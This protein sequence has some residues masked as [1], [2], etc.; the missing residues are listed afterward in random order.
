[1]DDGLKRV[2]RRLRDLI[3]PEGS[4]IQVSAF[5][6]LAVCGIVV[7]LITAFYNLSVGFGI[8]S[9]IE[10]MSGVFISLG[11]MVYTRRTGNYRMAM[12]LTVLAIFFGL[13][14]F[15]YLTNGGYYGGVPYFF[16]FATVFTAFL[17]DGIIMPVFVALELLWYAGLCIYTYYHPSVNLLEGNEEIRMM[18]VVVCETIVSIA[19]SIAMYLQI[20][21]YRKKQQ[22]LNEAI[23]AVREA[24]SAKSEF[25][26]KMS[27]DIRTPLNTIMAMNE[28]IVSNTSSARIREWV[29]DSNVSG[30]IL[31]S[32][33]DDMLD[34][35]RIEA[36]R[37]DLLEQPWDTEELFDEA[38]KAWKLQ[39]DRKG[40]DFYYDRDEHLPARLAGDEDV[41]RKITN[42]LLSNAVKYTRTGSVHLSVGWTDRLMIIV[43]D[44][45][46]GIAPEH[47]NN[48]FKPF[49]RG[50]QDIYRETS[51]SGLG[52]AIVKELVD[53][54][55]GSVVCESRLNHGTKFTVCLPEKT[56]DDREDAKTSGASA[57]SGDSKAVQQFVAPEAQI[58]VVDDNAYNRKVIEAFLEPTLIRI[59]DV[60]SG[61]EALEMIDIKHYDLVLMDLRMPGMD[62]AE[63]LEQIKRDYPDFDTP[64]VVLTADIMNGV[65][66][67]LLKQGFSGFLAKP[68][69]SPNLLSTIA[70]FIPDKVV[71]LQ[72]DEE[73]GLT[74]AR[75]ESFQDMLKP[76]G[77]DL[78]LAL[79]YNAG[80]TEE[81]LMRAGLF[82]DYAEENRQRLKWDE[83]QAEEYYLLV[84][85]IKSIARGVGAY[86]LAQLAE[87]IE[88]RKEDAFVEKTN[89]VLLDEYERVR[90]G[91]KKL[92][93]G[94]NAI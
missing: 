80:S 40:L 25:L 2:L 46:I 19:L 15:L 43:E 93:E 52:L 50:V 66:E 86:L 36:G 88:Y 20:R 55:G 91:L 21:V 22:Q 87:A 72:T 56:V 5:N 7:S 14:T 32:L 8:L 69:S 13:F 34:L 63:T 16:V 78:K 29:N 1:M 51:G 44:T 90:A 85:S 31:M 41:V 75:I 49:E 17:L 23:I 33:I 3:L 64:V 53:A 28:L 35:S 92:R 89:P 54:A 67:R 57:G 45:G 61:S 62:G 59:D 39:T 24:N 18:D 82:E 10:C 27:H 6:I 4:E 37:M 60:E 94:V 81:F 26:A 47:L 58:L 76:C 83:S 70:G 38:V 12:I 68:V 79:E 65:E 84:H 48:I 73:S 42:N 74:L 11:L 30:R 71:P 77:I 9:F